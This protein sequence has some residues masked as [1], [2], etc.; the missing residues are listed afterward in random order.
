MRIHPLGSSPT[1][2]NSSL[3]CARLCR[4]TGRASYMHCNCF[5][6]Q[7]F[8]MFDWRVYCSA[9]VFTVV[10]F[11]LKPCTTVSSSSGTPPAQSLPDSDTRSRHES[12]PPHRS[13]WCTPYLLYTRSN[14]LPYSR[15]MRSSSS[16]Y[17]RRTESTDSSAC[18]CSRYHAFA[19][20]PPS[21]QCVV[22]RRGRIQDLCRTCQN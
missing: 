11:N 14:L 22:E 1:L 7:P 12:P 20:G 4:T 2:N 21:C 18:D 9:I 19:S 16:L 6:T 13:G 8:G 3:N 15:R 17:W 10:S 5:R